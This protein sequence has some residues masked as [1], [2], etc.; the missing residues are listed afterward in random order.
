MSNHE[1][2]ATDQ[3]P[4]RRRDPDEAPRV[5]FVLGGGGVLGAAEV[6]MLRALHEAGIAPDVVLGTSVGALNGAMIAADPDGAVD[7]LETLW[8]GIASRDPFG[9]SFLERVTTIA[10]TGTHLHS[11]DRL[12]ALL[13]ETL[14]VRSFEELRLPF[15]C[16]AASIE[17]AGARWF[18]AGPLIPAV[19][20]STAVPGLLPP[21]EID[22]EHY[23]DG[24][25]V[26]SIPVGRAVELGATQIHVLQVG[27]IEQPLEAPTGPWE[28][29]VVAF[30]I[31]RRHRFVEEMARVPEG[32]AV[33][34]LP[35]GVESP[36]K[37]TD[38]RQLRYRDVSSVDE[39]IDAAYRATAGYLADLRR[40]R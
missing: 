22:G 31:A 6:G 2:P 16:V 1:Q 15:Q 26:H 11:S 33:H 35:T 17:R 3:Q 36:L 10:R 28:V 7:R 37:P 12:N 29:G 8:R 34:V 32:V 19:L 25:L 23:L 30:E 9:G 13:H 18:D 20:A 40:G 14:P 4:S 38:P 39:R 21:V 5:A 24:G 27:R